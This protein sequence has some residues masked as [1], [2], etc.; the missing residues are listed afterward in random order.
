MFG[1]IMRG[2]RFQRENDGIMWSLCR[3]DAR[4][5]QLPAPQD[6]CGGVKSKP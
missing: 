2:L 1:A 6:D 3:A 5:P 4:R